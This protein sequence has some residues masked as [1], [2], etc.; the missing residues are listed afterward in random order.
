MRKFTFFLFFCIYQISFAQHTGFNFISN[1]YI[2]DKKDP[3]LDVAENKLLKNL[4]L[5]KKTNKYT[6]FTVYA[7]SDWRME[8]TLSELFLNESAIP[9]NEYELNIE[10][11]QYVDSGSVKGYSKVYSHKVPSDN[12]TFNRVN[13][14]LRAVALG[15]YGHFLT[16]TEVLQI[17]EII[18]SDLVKKWNLEKKDTTHYSLTQIN[19]Y[20]TSSYNSAIL[21]KLANTINGNLSYS[22]WTYYETPYLSN[23]LSN[24]KKEELRVGQD[25]LYHSYIVYNPS[26]FVI[27]SNWHF[28]ITDSK[29]ANSS[30]CIPG[31]LK[32]TRE[33]SAIGIKFNKKVAYLSYQD[34]KKLC[35]LNRIDYNVYAHLFNK[36]II[37]TLKIELD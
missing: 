25:T 23:A 1:Y 27:V 20:D 5:A 17:A 4:A 33:I 21:N 35:V 36:C 29:Q 14:P 12:N 16:L 3:I 9:T 34:F 11:N 15:Q 7:R 18:K 10:W 30:K 37:D 13:R 6:P 19:I 28:T 26:D 22:Q 2:Q 24:Q 31:L 32:I 8:F